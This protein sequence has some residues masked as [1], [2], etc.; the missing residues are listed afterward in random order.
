MTFTRVSSFAGW[1]D[2]VTAGPFELVIDLADHDPGFGDGNI[3]TLALHGGGTQLNILLNGQT[4]DL[5]NVSDLTGIRLRGTPDDDRFQ[6]F[7]RDLPVTVV[8]DG[9]GGDD[10]VSIYGNSQADT[11]LVNGTSVTFN[12]STVLLQ[13]VEALALDTAQGNDTVTVRRTLAG[14]PVSVQMGD[15]TDQTTVGT[16]L[17]LLAGPLTV[18]GGTGAAD[19]VILS[20]SAFAGGGTYRL[21][22]SGVGVDR[23]PGLSL[24]HSGFEQ[25][26]VETGAGA[27]VVVVEAT[28]PGVVT[29]VNAGGGQ[30]ELVGMSANTTWNVLAGVNRG[31]ATG[32]L[33]FSG[34]E[35]L[36]GG[37]AADR[38]VLTGHLDGTID[39][40]A[41]SDTLVGAH[42][43]NL[44][45]I[46]AND[47]GN[48]DT[49]DFV[50]VENLAGGNADDRFLITRNRRVS[51]TIFGGAGNDWLDYSDFH[52][53]QTL[54]NGT[55]VAFVIPVSAN[56]TTG[57]VSGV[58][59]P[60]TSIERVR[61]GLGNDTLTGNGSHNVLIGGAGND[62]LTG[63]AGRDL[64]I[65]GVGGDVISGGTGDDLLVNGATVYDSDELGLGAIMAEWTSGRT[66]AQRVA[67]LK[68]GVGPGPLARLDA[69]TVPH[70]SSADRLTGGADPDWFFAAPLAFGII[71]QPPPPPRDTIVDGVIGEVVN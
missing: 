48:V 23:L 61:G 8:V 51:G 21:R 55:E 11:A 44:W 12:S 37:G 26:T 49:L 31:T 2:Q 46:T 5:P 20:D 27:D 68:T 70:D 38:F 62:L 60:A 24:V 43:N 6:L 47:A 66:Y 4:L 64:L 57:A 54:P 40:G 14:L 36:T 50:A 63:N 45:T 71:G 41:G 34:V 18:N 59:G 33:A 25:R 3:D 52:A 42:N 39:G 9:K 65:G 17:G 32:G 35:N 13:N 30:D 58:L 28:L 56:L 16:N 29:T 15:G 7:L 10:H 53:L 69:I 67:N 19:R 1:I 22:N